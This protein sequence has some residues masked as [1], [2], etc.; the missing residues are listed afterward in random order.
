MLKRTIVDLLIIIVAV[1]GVTLLLKRGD[2]AGRLT[3]PGVTAPAGTE[4]NQE[5]TFPRA[6]WGRLVNFKEPIRVEPLIL[7]GINRGTDSS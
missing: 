1:A 5:S 3:L 4:S 2:T 6:I 7:G